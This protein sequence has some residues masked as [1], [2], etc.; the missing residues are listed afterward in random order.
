MGETANRIPDVQIADTAWR[1]LYRVGGVAAL[2]AALVFRRNLAAEYVLLRELGLVDAGP[3]AFPSTASGWFAVLSSHRFVGLLLLN[4]F[5]LVNYALVG[6]I[7]LALFAILR[8][9]DTGAMTLATALSVV[10]I[11][12]YFASNQ[13]FALSSLSDQ[14]AA[15]ATEAERSM[16]LAA[17]QALLA[18]HEAGADYGTGLYISFFLVSLA[19]LIIATVMRRSTIFDRRTA[20]LGIL[21][22]VLGLGYYVVRVVAPAL[23][24][25]PLATSAPFLL[26]WYILIGL[27]LLRLARSA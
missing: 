5:D 27:R 21:A 24:A 26:V 1:G 6:L 7:F 12:V 14:Y 17:G 25:V 20:Y 13:A 11:A 10:G 22:N 8:R 2:V 15:A 4:L 9:V 16:A 18:I 19:G 3:A 23:I